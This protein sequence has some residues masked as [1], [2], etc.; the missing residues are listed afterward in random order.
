MLVPYKGEQQAAPISDL[1]ASINTAIGTGLG[2]LPRLP[3]ASH[4]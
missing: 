1:T 4:P 2:N 3:P